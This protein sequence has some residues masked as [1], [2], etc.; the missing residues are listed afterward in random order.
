MKIV[1]M[2]VMT[3]SLALPAYAQEKLWNELNANAAT[4]HQDGPYAEAAKPP[5]SSIV[6]SDPETIKLG[7]SLFEQNCVSCHGRKAVGE[8][9]ATPSGG[10]KPKVGHL[11]PALNGTGHTWHHPPG[12]LFRIIREGS[13]VKDSRM[14]AWAGRMNDFEILA[15]IAHFQSLWPPRIKD[16][17][18][19]RYLHRVWK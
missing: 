7:M 18:R 4:L 17:Y 6:S 10:W 13:V 12:Y 16:A 3:A 9:P 14:K 8:N 5:Q 11:A 15:V 1:L 2:V 19:H